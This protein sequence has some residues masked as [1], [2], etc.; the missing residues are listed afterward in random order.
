LIDSEYV[1]PKELSTLLKVS[2][3]WPYVMIKRGALSYCKLGKV[4]RFRR[5]DVEEFLSRSRVEVG[6]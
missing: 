4:I 2:R 3:A 6:R 5:S 1:T